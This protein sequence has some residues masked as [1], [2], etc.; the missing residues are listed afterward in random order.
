M[1]KLPVSHLRFRMNEKG[2][3][4]GKGELTDKVLSPYGQ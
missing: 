4:G 1:E 2:M 3:G